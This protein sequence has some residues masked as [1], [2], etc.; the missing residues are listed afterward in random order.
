[1]FALRCAVGLV[2]MMSGAG[3]TRAVAPPARANSHRS[4]RTRPLHARH[5]A[6]T[7]C[8][9]VYKNKCFAS[10]DEACAFAGCAD[11]R[12]DVIESIPAH[13]SCDDMR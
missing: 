11:Q 13:V 5:M 4:T 1:M 10:A 9:A 8:I 3:C 12:C 7:E 2:L 6:K